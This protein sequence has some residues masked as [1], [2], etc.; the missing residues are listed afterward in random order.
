[1]I[2]MGQTIAPKSDQ[3][4]ADDLIAGPMTITV[5]RVS[6]VPSSSDQPVDIHFQGDGGKP[7]KPCKSMR[8]VMVAM[9]GADATRYVGRRMTLYRDPEVMFGGMKVGG[10]RISHMSHI[11]GPRTMALTATRA[12][13]KPYTVKPLDD[14]P[15]TPPRG[16]SPN[17]P[18]A[19]PLSSDPP[20]DEVKA[21][22]KTL[23]TMIERAETHGLKVTWAEFNADSLLRVAALSPRLASWIKEVVPADNDQSGADPNADDASH[24]L[25]NPHDATPSPSPAG[26]ASSAA[27]RSM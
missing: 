11:D 27:E 5:T 26:G 23:R 18:R 13:R 2:D 16:P 25:M 24:G 6:A 8:R 4:N 12:S 22:G 1:M 3:L 19:L 14:A 20:E 10:I 17:E 15:Q 9:W 21:W 7:Y